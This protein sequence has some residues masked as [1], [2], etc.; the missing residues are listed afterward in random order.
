[1]ETQHGV[2]FRTSEKVGILLIL[3]VS[4]AFCM[5]GSSPSSEVSLNITHV[6][7]FLKLTSSH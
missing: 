7:M 2:Q 1:M 3:I 4:F 6:L 5:C